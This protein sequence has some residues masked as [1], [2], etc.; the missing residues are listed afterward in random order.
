[1]KCSCKNST[2]EGGEC[3]EAV[4]TTANTPTRISEPTTRT[5]RG[6][7]PHR[8]LRVTRGEAGRHGRRN[9]KA[10]QDRRSGTIRQLQLRRLISSHPL[11]LPSLPTKVSCNNVNSF[12][13][14]I[15]KNL[16]DDLIK[17]S[18]SARVCPSLTPPSTTS[19]FALI[20]T[21]PDEIITAIRSL[22][23]HAATG[24][25][26]ISSVVLKRYSNHLAPI[27]SHIFNLCFEHGVFPSALKK[28]I[29]HPIFKSG[30]RSSPNNYRPIAVLPSL[31]KILERLINWRFLPYLENNNLISP[32]QFGFR[33][34]ISTSDALL[35][36]TNTIVNHLNNNKKALAIFLDLA[37][38]FDTVPIPALLNKLSLIGV[39][40]AQHVFFRSYLSERLQMVKIGECLSD[41]LEISYGVPQGSILGPIL[42]L[43]FIN[44]LC[45]ISLTNGSIIT[46]ADDTV[47]LFDANTWIDIQVTAQTGFNT[48]HNWLLVVAAVKSLKPGKAPGID[49]IHVDM[50]RADAPMS[51]TLLFPLLT[52]IWEAGQVPA[53][54]KQGLLVK[55]PKKGD[56]SRC[57]NWRGITLLPAAAKVL[58]KILLNRIAPKVA[59]TLR[60]EQAG[61]RPGRSC[62]DHTNTL[63][64][65]IE[66][67]VEWQSELF[68]AFVD[69]EK[70]FDTVKWTALWSSLQRRGIPACII[71]VIRSLYEGST[72]RVV[73]E[74]EL[75][76]PIRISAGVKQGCLLSPLL[77]VILLD[78]VMRNVVAIPRGISWASGVLEDLDYA[79]DIVLISPTLDLLQE[80]LAHLQEEARVMGLRINRRKTV[81]MRIKAKTSDALILDDQRLDSVDAFTYLGSTV[82]RQGG[83]DEDIESR[84]K[85]AKA[86]FAQL[87]PVWD[88]NVLTRRIKISLFDSIVKSVLLFGCETWRVTKGLTNK[89]QVFV[90]K[91]LRSILR[92]FWPKTIRNEDL[93]KLC[94]QSPIGKEIAKRKWRWI[95]HT[96]RRGATNAATIAF[97]WRP[98]NGKR[99]R[100]RPVQ[101]WRRSVENELRAAGLS[102]SEAK[103]TAEDRRKWRT[104]VETLCTSGVP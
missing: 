97:D 32:N 47:L 26:G 80:K 70:A 17:S 74:K 103:S 1:M 42:F 61:F 77:F 6:G 24:G 13:V 41:E 7:A 95:G 36:L 90:N 8:P 62:T 78:D 53:E 48:I 27:L 60:D 52:R 14:N 66:Q 98:P 21:D 39:R 96:V 102:W 45:N 91:S 37:K 35:R 20:H 99:A 67:C 100:G 75:G 101:T 86:A 87:K 22:K 59:V 92:V 84:I 28:A 64:V 49:N 63:R 43:V 56:P 82:T 40:G 30:D 33:R 73:H 50:L 55:V 69:F 44:D 58:A 76:A 94:R 71:Q 15:G 81:D 18:Q 5:P 68:L 2:V 85:K 88:S 79:D 25:D 31:S 4:A 38:A 16:A 104:L 72:C 83:A 54:W 51:A 10:P 3:N 93:W 19:S 46:Y 34:N 57:D 29:I 23:P 65:L 89:L 9:Y 11:I 12:F